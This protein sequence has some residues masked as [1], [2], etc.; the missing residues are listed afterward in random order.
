M[1]TYIL[2]TVVAGVEAEGKETTIVADVLTDLNAPRQVLEEGVGTIDLILV[3]YRLSDGR[4]ITGT[5]LVLSHYEFKHPMD[6]RLTDE[7]WREMIESGDTLDRAPWI[8][9]LY[10][11]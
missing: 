5:G 7:K 8:Y 11:E 6:D 3:A 1:K 4:I 2:G 9:N 10:A